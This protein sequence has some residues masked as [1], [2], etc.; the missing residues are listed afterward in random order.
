MALPSIRA[1]EQA[2]H[3]TRGAAFSINVGGQ[4]VELTYIGIEPMRG[5]R[6]AVI[7]EAR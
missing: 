6:Y 5:K 1:V 3:L 7:L 4:Y 2:M